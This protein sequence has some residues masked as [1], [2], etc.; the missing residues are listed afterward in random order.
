ML[1][2]CVLLFFVISGFCIHYP[3]AGNT[4]KLEQDL[5]NKEDHSNLPS[6]L[7]RCMPKPTSCSIL[8]M[9]Q[10]LQRALDCQS[11]VNPKLSSLRKQS[12]QQ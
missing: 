6:L 8:R 10:S 11:A 12:D 2:E 4:T 5:R 9:D 3:M 1:G 7:C